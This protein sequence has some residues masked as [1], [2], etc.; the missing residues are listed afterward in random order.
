MCLGGGSIS[1]SAV[2]SS[3]LRGTLPGLLRADHE[4]HLLNYHP[5]EAA[6]TSG[7]PLNS[8]ISDINQL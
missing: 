1:L 3:A 8:H 7:T 6:H 2:R 5:T 4:P